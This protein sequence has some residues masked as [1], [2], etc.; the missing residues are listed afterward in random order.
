MKQRARYLISG[1]FF[2][3]IIS[4]L[5]YGGYLGYRINFLDQVDRGVLVLRDALTR[6]RQH[7][8]WMEVLLLLSVMAGGAA[9][10]L[11]LRSV[12]KKQKTT[13]RNERERFLSVINHIP[14]VIFQQDL[15]GRL[16]YANRA[17]EKTFHVTLDEA[18]GKTPHAFFP[19]D[20]AE[21]Y[22][23]VDE[24]VK[25]EDRVINVVEKDVNRRTGRVEYV[26]VTKVP[27]HNEQGEVIGMQGIFWPITR[28]VAAEKETERLRSYLANIVDSMPSV[29]MGVDREGCV[30][31]W[32]RRAEQE[33]GIS[34]ADA[35][36]QSLSAVFPRLEQE[37]DRIRRCIA[38]RQ[39]QHE[40][41]HVYQ[42]ASEIRYEA[43]TIY[44]LIANGVEGAVIRVDDITEKV[45]LEEMMIQS[46][47]ML[48]V[49]GLAAGMAHEINNPIAGMMQ[50]A[51]VILR[52]L[53]SDLPANHETAAAAG[54]SMAAIRTFLEERGIIRQLALIHE[55][56]RQAAKVVQNMLS[57][58]RKSDARAL[59]C[60]LS[61]IIDNTIEL[62]A[63][64]Y[65]LKK[66]YDFRDIA[67]E[68]HYDTGLPSVLCEESKLQ[69]VFLNIFRNGAEAMTEARQKTGHPAIPRFVVKTTRADDNALIEISDNG[70]GMDEFTRKR[71][72]EPFFTTKGVG[73]G[74][75]LG[76]SVAYFIITENHGGAMQVESTPGQ[77]TR[78]VI[79]LPLRG[80][81]ETPLL[82][83]EQG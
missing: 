6:Q 31:Q 51:D 82:G 36:G 14:H 9:W 67:I 75:G 53:E 18:L 63:H 64:D 54:T 74:T 77:G 1:L 21:Q 43:V 79:R 22:M 59:P 32:N 45:R 26:D 47:K 56:G 58:A 81:G 42:G 3:L 17:F 34:S 72:F 62:A 83:K 2:L 33:T 15:Q 50:N 30:T 40:A 61:A 25:R 12:D 41:T 44:P 57:F 27:L 11:G 28:T 65:D 76:L 66:N 38:S 10:F 24:R 60:E 49:G 52:R 7:Y 13:L 19:R 70:P 20:K 35:Q 23:A 78:F 29:L 69:Q 68:R 5:V 55:S 4:I 71:L 8:V 16:I 80:P 73:Q 39:V 46:E 37:M 48:S